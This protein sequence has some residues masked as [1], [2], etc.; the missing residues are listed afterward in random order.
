MEDWTDRFWAKVD[1]RGADECWKWQG[2]TCGRG[3]GQLSIDG[4]MVS[5]H[6]LTWEL[7][8]GPIPDD[9]CVLHRCDNPPCC[10]PRHLFLGTPADNSRDMVEKGRARGGS[11][12]GVNN[13]RAKLTR[14]VVR[15]IRSLYATGK[16]TQKTLAERFG[17]SKAQISHIVNRKRWAWLDASAMV[18]SD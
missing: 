17:I 8:D 18:K 4:K 14:Q 12:R 9:L 3:Y 1:M 13:G 5:A 10:N 2:C 11:L 7:T 16:H 6:R 15:A